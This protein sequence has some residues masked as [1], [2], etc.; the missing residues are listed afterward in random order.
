MNKI[1]LGEKI[2]SFKAEATS[3]KKFDLK[4]E[5]GK[6]I[7]LYFYPK[8]ATPGCTTEG[9]DFRDHYTEF[10]ELKTEIYGISRDGL[11]S[12]ENFK[13]KQSLPFDLISDENENICELFDVIKM[14]NLYGRK[15]KGIERSTFLI[16]E[17]GVLQKEWRNVKVS[18]HVNEVLSYIKNS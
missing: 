1:E 13:L 8:D 14:K 6:K 15:I 9:N 4:N 5:K 17:E 10:K 7:L 2:P 16:D 11:K 3:N 12:H 18:G